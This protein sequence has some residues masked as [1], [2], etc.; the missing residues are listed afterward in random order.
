MCASRNG[1]YKTVE[2]LINTYRA[3]INCQDKVYNVYNKLIMTYFLHC[4]Y[5][6]KIY[7]QFMSFRDARMLQY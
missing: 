1:Q 5:C 4:V 7:V 2:M 6:R 3:D